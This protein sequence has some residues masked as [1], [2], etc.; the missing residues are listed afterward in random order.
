MLQ[1]HHGAITSPV[2]FRQDSEYKAAVSHELLSGIE[3]VDIAKAR[4]LLEKR[5][6]GE[7]TPPSPTRP[8]NFPKDPSPRML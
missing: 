5:P 8:H 1:N 3:A 7:R 4:E 2:F 6:E